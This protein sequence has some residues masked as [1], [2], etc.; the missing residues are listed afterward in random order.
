MCTMLVHFPMYFAYTFL[1]LAI[2]VVIHI[3]IHSLPNPGCTRGGGG[4]LLQINASPLQ[5]AAAR[6]LLLVLLLHRC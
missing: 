1:S 3:E 4:V 5:S 6:L 2:V